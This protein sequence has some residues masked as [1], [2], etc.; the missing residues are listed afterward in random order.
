MLKQFRDTKYYSTPYGEI[1]TK[2][3]GRTRLHRGSID[4]YGYKRHQLF[5]GSKKFRRFAH[6]IVYECWIGPY[7]DN[8]TIDHI[9][10]NILNNNISNLRT[11]S[12]SQNSSR[13]QKKTSL[14]Q[15]CSYLTLDEIISIKKMYLSGI[16]PY[17]MNKEHGLSLTMCK[18]ICY[19]KT[20][21]DIS[22]EASP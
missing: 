8:L 2:T 9:D 5:S 21:T 14:Q 18:N 22:I 7:D 15:G 20:Y 19:G 12:H 1:Y 4:K 13:K 17:R 10:F 16:T 11:V 3:Y 6:Q